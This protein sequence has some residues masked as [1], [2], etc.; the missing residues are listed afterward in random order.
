MLQGEG[1]LSLHYALGQNERSVGLLHFMFRSVAF[2]SPET[3][4][5]DVRSPAFPPCSC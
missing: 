4:C 5:W 2:A 1:L 3:H